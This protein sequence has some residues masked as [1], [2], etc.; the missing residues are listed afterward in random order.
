M[1]QRWTVWTGAVHGGM[2]WGMARVLVV[3]DNR[4]AAELIAEALT[5]LGHTTAIAADGEQALTV[6]ATF[7]PEVALIDLGLPG[8]DGLEVARRLRAMPALGGVHLIAITGYGGDGDRAATRDAGFDEH[9]VKPVRVL[10]LAARIAAI[11]AR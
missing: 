7:A 9:L 2:R 10:E 1:D 4:D 5:D 8:I 11:A 3:D 6:T